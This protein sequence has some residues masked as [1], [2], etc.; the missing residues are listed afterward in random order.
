LAQS[1]R[2]IDQWDDPADWAG[3]V[4]KP[5]GARA[6]GKVVND[7]RADWREAWALFPGLNQE[8]DP[9]GYEAPLGDFETK[10]MDGKRGG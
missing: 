4:I 3:T 10:S 1:G 2:P 8:I 5:I 7:D 6:V 9:P